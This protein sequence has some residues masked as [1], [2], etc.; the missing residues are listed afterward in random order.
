M[1]LRA[2]SGWDYLRDDRRFKA[3]VQRLQLDF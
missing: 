3:L 2:E 1:F